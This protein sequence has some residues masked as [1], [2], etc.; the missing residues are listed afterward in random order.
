[1]IPAYDAEFTDMIT[2]KNIET[3]RTMIDKAGVDRDIE[4]TEYW[5]AADTIEKEGICHIKDLSKDMQDKLKI[6]CLPADRINKDDR[7]G[8]VSRQDMEKYTKELRL[9]LHD[10]KELDDI[11]YMHPDKNEMERLKNIY[12]KQK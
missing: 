5:K 9:L 7:D 3:I 6:S 2:K 1:M 12:V 10:T 8:G 11:N 4:G